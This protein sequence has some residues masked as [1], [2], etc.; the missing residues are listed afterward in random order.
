VDIVYSVVAVVVFCT[1]VVLFLEFAWDCLRYRRL[2]IRRPI[3]N[4]MRLTIEQLRHRKK[5][6]YIDRV[7]N[8]E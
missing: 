2:R 5:L 7:S 8:E 6:P 3:Q 4:A 1:L